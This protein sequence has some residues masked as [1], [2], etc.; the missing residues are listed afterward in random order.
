MSEGVLLN[1]NRGGFVMLHFDIIISM[2]SRR[3]DIWLIMNPWFIR[4]IC[5]CNWQILNNGIITKAKVLLPSCAG[6]L[7]RF[8]LPCFF[9]LLP[10]IIRLCSFPIFRHCAYMMQVIVRTWWRLLIVHDAGYWSYLMKVINRTWWR[11]L[12]VHDAGYWSYLMKVIVRTWWR[13]FW[14]Y[15]MQ[16][17]PETRRAH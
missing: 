4:Y 17:I 10:K 6:D 15:M 16:V 12:I 9:L 2:M 13:L 14:A 7:R 3:I 1:A 11:L 5:N 8:W